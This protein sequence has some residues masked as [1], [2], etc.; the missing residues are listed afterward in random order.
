M[1]TKYKITG[2]GSRDSNYG[3]S[4]LIGKVGRFNFDT[5]SYKPPQGFSYGSFF[6]DDESWDC[7]FCEVQLEAVK[8]KEMIISVGGVSLEINEEVLDDILKSH[9]Y[10]NKFPKYTSSSKGKIFIFEMDTRHIRNA[11]LKMWRECTA[12]EAVK[13]RNTVSRFLADDLDDYLIEYTNSALVRA[14]RVIQPMIPNNEFHYLLL[15]LD[16]REEED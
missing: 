8:E 3:K 5:G 13:A 7:Y 1:T 16:T 15:E 12:T 6:P 4:W 9:G 11:L 14:L 2:I 10:T